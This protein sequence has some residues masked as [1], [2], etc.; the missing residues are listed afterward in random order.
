MPAGGEA[1]RRSITDNH[2]QY[3]SCPLLQLEA[4]R[5]RQCV[6]ETMVQQANDNMNARHKWRARVIPIYAPC[7]TRTHTTLSL[8]FCAPHTKKVRYRETATATATA[9]ATES[10]KSMRQE[11]DVKAHVYCL[12]AGSGSPKGLGSRV[13][14]SVG[15]SPGLP[16]PLP[17]LLPP[18]TALS[19]SES[20]PHQI[21]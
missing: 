18:L 17:S 9:T 7:H 1:P 4:A 8:S 16:L 14:K 21:N 11:R 12:V 2:K 6:E 5:L 15:I 10:Q 3:G 13:S 20:N 19:T